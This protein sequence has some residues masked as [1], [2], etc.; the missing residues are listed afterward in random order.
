MFDK[1]KNRLAALELAEAQLKDEIAK[2]KTELPE[3][4]VNFGHLT[5]ENCALRRQN[6]ELIGFDIVPAKRI[7]RYD[8]G[9]HDES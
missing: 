7:K 3:L 2:L 6:D 8:Y 1:L 9:A 5:G 4:K